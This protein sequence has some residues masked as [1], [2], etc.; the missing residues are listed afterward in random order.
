MKVG[1]AGV[2]G[3]FAL[4]V[5]LLVL[6]RPLV[7]IDETRYMAVAWEMHLSGDAFHLTRN[8]ESY[9]H[10]PPL[11]FWLINLVW[12]AGG[13]SEFAA[14]LVGPAF[15]VLSV[16]G[17]GLLARRLWPDND[18]VSLRAVTV[19]AGFTLF[20]I[21]GSTTMFD[22]LLTVIVLTGIALI[23]RIGAG[24]AGRGVWLALGVVFA[25]GVLAK[26]PV[27]LL[28][29]LPVV[30][31][32]RVWA[33]APPPA[34]NLARGLGMALA[35]GL[36]LVCLWLVPALLSGDAAFRQDLLWNQSVSRVNGT[37]GHG[38]PFWFLL[39]LLPVILF[40]WGWSWRLWRAVPAA[41]RGDA[42]GRMCLI[43][44]GSAL[45]LFSAVGGKQVHYLLPELPA[46]ALLLAR[47]MGGGWADRRGGSL[48]LLVP[49]VLGLAALVFATG[50]LPRD[51]ALADLVPGWAVVVFGMGCLGLAAAS[52]RLPLMQAH[53][54][55]GLGGALMLHLLVGL[56]G[57]GRTQDTGPI[58]QALAAHQADGMAVAGMPYNADFNFAG[59]LT[60]PVATPADAA[61]LLIWAKA[62]PD[63]LV[64]GPLDRAG[65]TAPPEQ[66]WR[67][68]GADYGGW[69][70]AAVIT[71]LE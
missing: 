13:V 33:P 20:A 7:P 3:L 60:S 9:S 1:T 44:A 40:P 53:L 26:G 19:L 2:L 18:G 34:K 55:L 62:H 47:A 66:T 70:A 5:V 25:L 4:S 48:A 56:T 36:G 24:D 58:A 63:G 28:H 54:A 41:V 23:W 67:F 71:S 12:L 6:A 49:V 68:R 61:G 43:W 57:L 51:G 35:L 52:L 27:I 50:L 29:L 21:F 46:M 10:K 22:A 45:V 17:T 65:L 32:L 42:A 31:T 8:F 30:L 38:R 64:V 69:A 14:R 37:L 15:A 59:R 11:L 39:A 16:C